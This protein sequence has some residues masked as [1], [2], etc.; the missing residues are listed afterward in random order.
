MA[1]K[2]SCQAMFDSFD[3]DSRT[4][5]PKVLLLYD[6]FRTLLGGGWYL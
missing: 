5:N 4:A 6:Q 2:Y 3:L 1:A